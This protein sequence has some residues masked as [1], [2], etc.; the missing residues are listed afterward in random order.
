MPLDSTFWRQ[1]RADDF[2]VPP[3]HSLAALTDE[4][5]ALLDSTDPELRDTIGYEVL[6]TWMSRGLLPAEAL[7]RLAGTLLARLR[8]G[9]GERDTDSVFGRSFAALVLAEIVHTDNKQPVLTQDDVRPLVQPSLA[10]FGQERDRRGYLP[11]RGW[12][13][14]AAHGADLLGALARSRHTRQA[15]LEWIVDAIADNVTSPCE[16]PYFYGEDDRLAAAAVAAIR[17]DLLTIEFLR[18]WL[19]SMSRPQGRGW[20]DAYLDPQ[21]N[22][23]AHNTMAFL[24]ALYF[25]LR[26]VVSDTTLPGSGIDLLPGVEASIRGFSAQPQ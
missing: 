5:V 13:H 10:W 23:A 25:Q 11:D 19:L 16:F 15:D 3:D 17:R 8:D 7:R 1:L 18:D 4:L 26:M 21:R 22:N 20:H 2:A 12:A 24:R 6:A 14:A 9:L